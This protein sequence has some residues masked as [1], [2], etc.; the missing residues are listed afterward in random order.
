MSAYCNN[1]LIDRP[2]RPL[3]RRVAIV[4]AGTI[5]PDI[6]YYL[7]S[8]IAGL[9]LVM[10]DLSQSALDRA[11]ARIHSYAAKGVAKGKLSEA[12][13][14]R[15]TAG[16]STSTEYA[17][18][19]GSDWVIESATENLPLKR[20]IFTEVE[21]RVAP[22]ALITSN[23]S[24][25]PAAR[26]FSHLR[27]PERATVT[28]F[29]APAFLNPVV[30]VIDWPALEREVLQHLRWLFAST[31]KV[32]LVTADAVC[33][34]LD[35]I[36]DNWC[37]E[38]GY[39]LGDATAEEID[40][41]AQ[42]F[43]AAGPF[44]VLNLAN[45]NPI[46][47]EAN[48][49]QAEE[50]GQHYRAAAVFRS[51]DRW[52]TLPRGQRVEVPSPSFGTIRDRLLGILFSQS[53]DILD[54]GIG[55]A[56]DLE[57][58]SRLAFGFKAGPFELMRSCGTSE[59]E[60]VL[61]RLQQERPGMPGP[62][63]PIGQYQP[64]RRHVLVDELDGVKVL[65]IRRPEALNAL[66]DELNDELL[67]AIREFE[68]DPATRGF[69]VTGYGNRAFCA[70]AD[71]EVFPSLLGDAAAATEYARACSRLLVHIDA[72]G[73][74]VVAALNGI[75]LGGGLE[76]AVRCHGLVGV[77]DAWLQ[78]PEITLGIVPGIGAMVVPYRRWPEA[79]GVFHDMLR[80]ASKLTAERAHALGI[81]AAVV[82]AQCELM[83]AALQLVR[84]LE[85]VS[86]QTRDAA[87]PI[88]PLAVMDGGGIRHWS[89]E[90]RAIMDGAIV[91]AAAA[92]RWSDALEVGYRAF[93]A[94]ACTA[95]AREG[96]AAFRERRR[97]D[98]SRTG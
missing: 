46:I 16:I 2:T 50:E 74:P 38:A 71:I 45:G 64:F 29:F 34:M 57:L 55:T 48:S 76:L 84:Q 1:P 21:S 47:V 18:L 94:S 6:A 39:L 68:R 83:P 9:E 20:A 30:E 60:R 8:A 87:V 10:I 85:E 67:G 4:G 91:A 80:Q 5:G 33:F 25:L 26:L 54:R 3:P 59:T 35:R 78:F 15:A 61:Q 92:N 52:K 69:I 11:S 13:A 53:V 43:V 23:T 27:H 73:K 72:M 82:D 40:C 75:A 36:F 98:F 49:L 42:E 89:R 7:K 41:V 86:Y 79:S 90:V 97:A 32:P 31:G 65:T 24:S 28:H 56:A 88:A 12:E 37:N 17:V 96:I 77:R 93:G 58:G 62:A 63:R 51:V 95:A 70:G 44:T 14:A 66:H 19:E 81:L 22:D